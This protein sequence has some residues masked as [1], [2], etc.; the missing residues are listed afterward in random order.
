VADKDYQTDAVKADLPV[1]APL[2]GAQLAAMINELATSA[3]AET[4]AAYRR[5]GA[6]K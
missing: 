3:T 4:I 6:A 5:L 1:G 2:E